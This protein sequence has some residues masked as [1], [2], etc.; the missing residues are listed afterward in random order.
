MIDCNFSFKQMIVG[1]SKMAVMDRE[2]NMHYVYLE[3]NLGRVA[4]S[5]LGNTWGL[6]EWSQEILRLSVDTWG[7][8]IARK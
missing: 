7:W 6:W 3:S 8:C 2:I 1:H 5:D 4:R